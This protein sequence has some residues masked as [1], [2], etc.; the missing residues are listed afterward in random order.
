MT[1][2]FQGA[3]FTARSIAVALTTSYAL[4][5][6]GV[7]A[8]GDEFPTS[9][10]MLSLSSLELTAISTATSIVWYVSSDIAGDK[11]ITAVRT[12]T[13]VAGQSANVGG[14]SETFGPEQH[15]TGPLYVWA[16][17]NAGTATAK[18]VIRGQRT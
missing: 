8:E 2:P 10:V 11:P 1:M 4:L 14:V 16:K 15:H 6:P 18:A 13:I 3:S 7:A 12:T 5:T 17:T 9:G